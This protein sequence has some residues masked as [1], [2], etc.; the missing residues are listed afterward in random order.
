MDSVRTPERRA[1]KAETGRAGSEKAKKVTLGFKTIPARRTFPTK[2]PAGPVETNGSSGDSRGVLR[3]KTDTNR[4]ETAAAPANR[5]APPGQSSD[6]SKRKGAAKKSKTGANTGEKFGQGP[7]E[8]AS[9]NGD[10]PPKQSAESMERKKKADAIAADLWCKAALGLTS[11]P[12][13]RF[14]GFG[15]PGTPD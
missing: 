5:E 10:L 4:G 6:S 9:A 14:P 2:Q 8:A 3:R 12:V 11:I 7:R 15:Q 1:A 13:D